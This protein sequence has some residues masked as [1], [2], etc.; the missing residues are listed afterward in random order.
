MSGKKQRRRRRYIVPLRSPENERRI[1]GLPADLDKAQERFEYGLV[2]KDD[3]ADSSLP[4][5]RSRL[6]VLLS[7]VKAKIRGR[8]R[9]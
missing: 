8:M 3:V 2:T 5:R 9:K 7:E 4:V 6:L 1:R